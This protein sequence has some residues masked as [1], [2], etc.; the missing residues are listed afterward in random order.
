M[1]EALDDINSPEDLEDF[2]KNIKISLMH[3]MM[4]EE[5]VK[6]AKSGSALKKEDEG[7]DQDVKDAEIEKLKRIKLDE[8]RALIA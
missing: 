3:K 5:D 6:A 4:A 1:Q 7:I 8:A 2:E